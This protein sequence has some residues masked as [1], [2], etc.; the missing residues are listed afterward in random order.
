MCTYTMSYTEG[1]CVEPSTLHDLAALSEGNLSSEGSRRLAHHLT[2]CHLCKQLFVAMFSTVAPV[3]AAMGEGEAD[4]SEYR[5]H[6][7]VEAQRQIGGGVHRMA[8]CVGDVGRRDR[9]RDR[10]EHR[11]VG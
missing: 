2:S 7:Q 11:R 3:E 1:P 6:D 10:A 9:I 5:E 8:K 4:D